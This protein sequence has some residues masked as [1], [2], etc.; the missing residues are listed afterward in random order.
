VTATKGN[1][2]VPGTWSDNIV[3]RTITANFPGAAAPLVYLNFTWTI[4]D[5]YTDSV[6]ARCMDTVNNYPNYLQLK[7]Q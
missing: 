2:S 1:N 5:S 3:A 4:K 7:K 6:S